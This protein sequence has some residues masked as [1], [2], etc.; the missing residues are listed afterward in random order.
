MNWIN[1]I[2]G[3][4]FG[5]SLGVRFVII[6]NN[7]KLKKYNKSIENMFYT[8][9]FNFDKLVSTKR[10]NNYAYFKYENWEIIYQLSNK[11]IH[12]FDKEQCLATSNQ[13]K[14]SNVI[15]RLLSNIDISWGKEIHNTVIIDDNEVSINFIE[16]QRKKTI[17][18]PVLDRIEKENKVSYFTIDDILDKINKVGYNNLTNEE[19]DFLNNASK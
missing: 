16:D 7:N 8:V 10:I 11:S 5:F 19:K 1:V 18:D 14:K 13:L 4:L 9:L 17:T 2:I 12:L 6:V 3:I 15:D